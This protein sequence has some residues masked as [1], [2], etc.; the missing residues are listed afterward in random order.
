MI[1]F[2]PNPTV[3]KGEDRKKEEKK[4]ALK[5]SSLLFSDLDSRAIR[6]VTSSQFELGQCHT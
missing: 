4:E 3:H 2:N 6:R 5:L 1:F